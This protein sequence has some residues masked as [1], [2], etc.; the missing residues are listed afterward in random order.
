MNNWYFEGSSLISIEAKFLI[1]SSKFV[2][3][4]AIL[5]CL[6]KII[7]FWV[8][9]ISLNLENLFP[10]GILVLWISFLLSNAC[11]WNWKT[12]AL[13]Y[14][15]QYFNFFFFR[16]AL[17]ILPWISIIM[18]ALIS[19]CVQYYF[20]WNQGGFRLLIRSKLTTQNQSK[21]FGS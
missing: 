2:L 9:T 10:W 7:Q 4:N 19:K 5:C 17:W 18:A 20:S 12:P 1:F 11:V 8:K 16:S 6:L 15:F 21:L 13:Y 14:F 3:N